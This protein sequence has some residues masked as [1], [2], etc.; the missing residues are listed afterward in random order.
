MK[1]RIPVSRSLLGGCLVA[2]LV[3][4]AASSARAQDQGPG[5]GQGQR[6]QRPPL[7]DQ[8][9]DVVGLTDDQVT[10]IKALEEASRADMLKARQDQSGEDGQPDQNAIREKMRTL[11]TKLR[12]DVRGLLTAEQQTKF[13][14]WQKEQDARRA[15][16]GNRGGGQGGGQQ[17]GSDQT[18]APSAPARD[19]GGTDVRSI[20][21]R[22]AGKVQKA[23][24][25]ARL[26]LHITVGEREQDLKI[27]ATGT[28]IDASGLVAVSA[29]ALDPSANFRGMGGRRGG[30]AGGADV[31]I[32]T[33]VTETKLVL[34][35]GSEIDA[36]VVVKDAD[37]DLAFLRPKTTT[38]SLA[39]VNLQSTSAGASSVQALDEVFVVGRLGRAANRAPSLALGSVRSVVS[40]PHGFYVLDD[41]VSGGSVGCI[42][43]AADGTPLGICVTKRAADAQGAPGP[44]GPG[45]GRGGRGDTAIVVRT[46]SDILAA[47]AKVQ[48]AA[49]P[50]KKTEAPE[51]KTAN[52]A[53]K[54]ATNKP[55]EKPATKPAPDS[56]SEPF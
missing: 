50:E 21:R 7:S 4:G 34:D 52:P 38:S 49:K 41:Q 14:E 40:G 3:L 46:V 48:G 1:E 20:A 5:Q 26:G 23:V 22:V 39:W 53:P 44:G 45:M 47:A 13:D 51:K 27:E 31:E 19:N 32:E 11:Q 24:V 33:E 8:L 25:T 37:L 12:T 2:A 43:F 6:R 10:K 56:K 55:A 30:G 16:R 29:S 54:N 42:A 36:E 9:K 15:A 18:P 28:V 17:R 35:D